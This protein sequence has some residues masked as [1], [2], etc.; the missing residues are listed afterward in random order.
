MNE[1]IDDSRANTVT[2]MIVS[3]VEAGGIADDPK[4]LTRLRYLITLESGL[5]LEVDY[6]RKKV[7]LLW[8]ERE[9]IRRK[10]WL[11]ANVFGKELPDPRFRMGSG[12]CPRCR[13]FKNFQKECPLCLSLE[14]TL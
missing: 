14:M 12:L 7:E 4:K 10:D 3:Y 1:H 5:E 13:R 11:M 2:S 9:K 6:I 8:N